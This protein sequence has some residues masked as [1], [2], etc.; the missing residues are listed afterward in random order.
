VLIRAARL[1][2]PR[3]NARVGRYEV[4]LLWPRQRLVVEVDGFAYHSSRTAFERDRRRDAELQAWGYRVLRITWRRL[5][6]EPN[7]VVAQ[8]AALLSAATPA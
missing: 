7:A 2:A 6:A 5:V 4:D 3:T 8:L 1:A